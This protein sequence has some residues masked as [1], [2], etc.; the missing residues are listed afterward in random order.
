MR[1]CSLN[2]ATFLWFTELFVSSG[3][4]AAYFIWQGAYVPGNRKSWDIGLVWL[5]LGIFWLFMIW[6]NLQWF[7]L[8]HF[9]GHNGLTMN[10]FQI[11]MCLWVLTLAIA[12]IGSTSRDEHEKN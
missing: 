12:M 2:W 9:V 1:E 5:G 10:A 6:Q 11:E 4:S 8:R 3:V 7:G